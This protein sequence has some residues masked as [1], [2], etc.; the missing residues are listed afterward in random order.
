MQWELEEVQQQVNL[1]RGIYT[2]LISQFE[3][4]KIEQNDNSASE[5]LIV[6]YPI[7]PLAPEPIEAS[8]LS[9]HKFVFL[10][11]LAGLG[12]GFVVALAR[13]YFS[14]VKEDEKRRLKDVRDKARLN[15]RKL[16]PSIRIG[17]PFRK[18]SSFRD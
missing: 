1:Y 8:A 10:V 16:V 2:S 18:K 3:T 11:T 7:P 15:L 17:L 9:P 4:V 13:G 14:I 6:D 5:P 12:F